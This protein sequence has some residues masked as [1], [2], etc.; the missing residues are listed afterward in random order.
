MKQEVVRD[1]L[2]IIQQRRRDALRNFDESLSHLKDNETY[3]ELKKQH[4][5]L[6][7]ENAR[8]EAYGEKTDKE[9]EKQLEKQISE[10]ENHQKPKFHCEK[11]ED[12]GIKNGEWC[13]CLKHEISNLLLKNSGFEN[14]ECFD[15]SIKTCGDLE[16]VYKLMKKWCLSD[17]KKNLVYVAGPTGVGKTH[18]IRCMAHEMIERNKIVKIVTAFKMNMDFG[19]HRKT[20]DEELLKKYLDCEILFI[21]DLGT[22]PLINNVTVDYFYLII[23]ER[24]MRHLPTVITSNLDMEDLKNRYEERI[25]S[26]I[27]D[28]ETSITIYLEGEDKRINKK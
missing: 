21:D 5:K 4:T 1:A 6:V 12:L 8:K 25:F 13:D 23:N 9:T 2:N 16:P 10:L 28:R 20:K 18:L 3:E 7:I 11:C 26:R 15:D 24:K 22:E 27:A 19:E 17:F 14:L